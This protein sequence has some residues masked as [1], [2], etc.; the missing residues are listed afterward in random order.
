L[1]QT[2]VAIHALERCE[3]VTCKLAMDDLDFPQEGEGS[4]QTDVPFALGLPIDN[5]GGG[6]NA[7][8]PYIGIRPI[9][10]WVVGRG[11]HENLSGVISWLTFLRAEQ[12]TPG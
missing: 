12:L 5:L 6:G 2:A 4:E 10:P 11:R 9:L 8:E 7:A 1:G 3:T